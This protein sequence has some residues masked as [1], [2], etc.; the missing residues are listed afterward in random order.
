MKPEIHPTYFPSAKITCACG[1]TVTVGS[2]KNDI[3]VEICNRCHPFFTGEEKYIDTEGRVER[4]KRRA[5]LKS[6]K[7]LHEEK[8]Q[9][10]KQERPRTLKEILQ[11]LEK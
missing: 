4:F 9:E 7:K 11:A 2:T 1:N 6:E 3:H 8:P 10:A 5:S